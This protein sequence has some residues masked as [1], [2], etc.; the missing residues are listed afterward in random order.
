MAREAITKLRAENIEPTLDDIILLHNLAQK[1]EEVIDPGLLLF[2]CRRVGNIQIYPMTIGARVW[3]LST[4]MNWFSSD[5]DM[6]KL[7][8]LYAY[9]NSRQPE[10]L[11]KLETPKEARKEINKWAS[12]IN[13]T[14]DEITQAFTGIID[15]DLV[16][17]SVVL[18]LIEQ[19]KT[20][21][22]SL[23]LTKA[24]KYTNKGTQ[25]VEFNWAIPYI[26]LLMHYYPGK[27][28]SEWLWDTSEDICFE[29][30]K[31]ACEFEQGKDKQ[32]DPND[33]SLIAFN[34]FRRAVAIIRARNR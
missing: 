6:I 7:S 28:E 30:I 18:D 8:V 20:N 29:M 14:E 15:E 9:C 1:T 23:D 21:P 19:I 22:T 27:K 4:A 11:F 26:S 34:N 10:K 33:P 17:V 16:G 3:I 31:K 12:T 5:E 13:I 24:L 32:I 25:E 2:Q